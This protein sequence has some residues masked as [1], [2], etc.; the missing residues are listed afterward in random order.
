MT[1]FNVIE[2]TVYSD[3]AL[4]LAG[5]V[6]GVGH[7]GLSMD[8]TH[9][10]VKRL[11]FAQIPLVCVMLRYLKEATRY[12]MDMTKGDGD[13]NPVYP[14]TLYRIMYYFRLSPTIR[15]VST[16]V[17]YMLFLGVKTLLGYVVTKMAQNII[18]NPPR[19]APS[20]RIQ[21]TGVDEKITKL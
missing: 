2:C 1:K 11:G 8:H 16:L 13:I 12:L 19:L 3:Y 7:E 21:A 6:T 9:A 4:I 18:Y 20:K 14:H 5:D 15:V 17:L 10:V